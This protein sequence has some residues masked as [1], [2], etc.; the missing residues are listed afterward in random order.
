[1]PAERG[2]DAASLFHRR[3]CQIKLSKISH[4][5]TLLES[6]KIAPRMHITSD[7]EATAARG[8]GRC[9][10]CAEKKER[11]VLPCSVVNFSMAAA[12]KWQVHHFSF[13]H[14]IIKL[15]W[16]GKETPEVI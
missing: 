4:G 9:C 12:V 13:S 11:T 5:L 15:V 6:S 2:R 10:S 1:M 16:E 8:Q 3:P 14:I 7:G